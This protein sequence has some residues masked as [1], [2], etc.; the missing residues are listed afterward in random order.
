MPTAYKLLCLS[1]FNSRPLCEGK[2]EGKL[3]T[4]LD[5]SFKVC[6]LYDGLALL[7][8]PSLMTLQAI[9][10]RSNVGDLQCASFCTAPSIGRQAA[11]PQNERDL[12]GSSDLVV[13]F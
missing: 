11:G 12:L 6:F 10:F 3:T 2:V 4:E 13:A 7:E 5:S 1:E 9:T 8:T